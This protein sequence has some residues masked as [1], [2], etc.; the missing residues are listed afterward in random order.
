MVNHIKHFVRKKETEADKFNKKFKGKK[1]NLGLD[2]LGNIVNCETP[3]PEII[4]W[5][6]DNG[7][8]EV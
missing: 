5:L 3:D 6:K 8:D 1:Y 4:Q 7:L 2:G